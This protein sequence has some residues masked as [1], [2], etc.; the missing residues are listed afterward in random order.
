MKRLR[1]QHNERRFV[2]GGAKAI[3]GLSEN[4]GCELRAQFKVETEKRFGIISKKE[5]LIYYYYFT[6]LVLGTL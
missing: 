6:N 3:V 1:P 2:L 5:M 4:V